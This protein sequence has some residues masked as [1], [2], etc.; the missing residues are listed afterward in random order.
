MSGWNETIQGLFA[1]LDPEKTPAEWA[2][3]AVEAHAAELAQLRAE[4]E[5]LQHD[6]GRYVQINSDLATQL[7]ASEAS[8]ARLR[9]VAVKAQREFCSA[10]RVRGGNGD[11][12]QLR[13]A[14]EALTAEDLA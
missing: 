13:A 1:G 4:N 8:R 11:T 9:N 5:A 12:V 14:L 7:A 6:I 10:F 2:A 3:A